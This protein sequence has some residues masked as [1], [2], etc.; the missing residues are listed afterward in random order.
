[1]EARLGIVTELL[2]WSSEMEC[3]RGPPQGVRSCAPRLF[4]R[5][6]TAQQ[7]MTNAASGAF[8]TARNSSE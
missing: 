4:P 7:L 5:A 8:D 6:P 1:M 3:R 2:D